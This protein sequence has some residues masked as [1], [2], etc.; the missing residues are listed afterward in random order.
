MTTIRRPQ[1]AFFCVLVIYFILGAGYAIRTPAWQA[2]DEP[3][4][5]NY[6]AQIAANGCCPIIAEG[7]WDQDYL[8]T[9]TTARFAPDLLDRFDA[10]QYE[11]H[12]PPLYYLLGAPIYSLTGGSLLALRL[13][14]VVLGAG[15]IVLTYA[16]GLQVAPG[17]PW[18]AVTAAAFVAFLPQHTAILASVNNDALSELVIAVGLYA[19]IR[20]LHTPARVP[21]WALGVI[22]GIG[23]LTKA[24][25][26]FL[27]GLV[28]IVLVAQTVLERQD[29]RRLV[30]NLAVFLV[31][32]L[33]IASV[34]WL[35][36]LSVYGVPDFLGLRAHDEVVVGQ[37][38]TADRIAEWGWE[39]FL[40]TSFETT[41]N[42]FFGQFG[43]MALPMP[44]WMLQI[45]ALMLITALIGVVVG[46]I[47]FRAGTSSHAQRLV[48]FVLGLAL[49]FGI[50]QFIYYNTTFVQPQGRYL[51]AVLVPFALILAWGWDAWSRLIARALPAAVSWIAV[52]PL[53]IALMLLP[54]NAYN[55]WR[56]IPLLAP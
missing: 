33:A 48:W 24:S 16:I 32:S 40:T 47:V 31:V 25:T 45:F 18:L 55:L 4:H 28:P 20:R 29:R 30:R 34:W 27:F 23:A 6:I 42:S 50:A 56:F 14:S 43:W 2:P 11:D 26:L 1:I 35:R 17:R 10:I 36:N 8:S 7:D 5:Y 39:A 54:M 37:L 12:Q 13:F 49:A 53:A 15:V 38:R 19:L 41:F 44:A 51:F 3:A 21:I 46:L 9:L 52:L 22:V